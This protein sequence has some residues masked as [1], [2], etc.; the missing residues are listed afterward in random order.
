MK[1]KDF[2][3][4]MPISKKLVLTMKLTF[5]LIVLNVVSCLASVYAQKVSLDLHNVKFSVAISEISKQTHLDFAYS[6]DFV[7]LNR[8]VS[9]SVNNTDL[10]SVLNKL[11]EGTDLLHV[12]LNGKIFL[13]PKSLD[14]AIKATFM[15]QQKITGIITDSSTGEPIPGANIVIE[16]SNAGA[17]SDVN[18]KFSIEVSNPNSA[19]VVSF[20]GYGKQRVEIANRS[21]IDVKL[22]PD[23][24][25]L[26]EVVVIGYGTVQKKNLVSAVDQVKASTIEHKPTAT[27]MQALQGAAPSLIIQQPNSEPGAGLNINIR[28]VSTMND[29]SP[30]VV[31]D[32]LVGGDISLLNPSDV[33]SVSILKD[34]GSAAIYGSR[35]AGGVILVTTKKGAKNSQ[36]RVTVNTQTGIQAPHVLYKPVKGYENAILRNQALVNSGS[37]P[38][39]S[40]ETIRQLKENGDSEWFLNTI[41]QNSLQQ[42]YNVSISGGREKSTYMI[43]GGYMS[44]E[45]NLVGPDYG[46]KR[47]NFRMNM[48]NEYGRLKLTTIMAYARSNIKTHTSST[49]TLIVDAARIP[50]YYY[51]KLKDE[52]GRYL[53]NDVLTEFNPLGILEQGG[54]KNSDNDDITANISA[55]LDVF[56]GLK[57]KGVFGGDLKANHSSLLE[58]KVNYYSSST[59]TIP[60]GSSGPTRR[61]EDD[62][63][64]ALFLNSQVMLDYSQK[65]NVHQVNALVGFSNE[66]YTSQRNG[67]RETYT[68]PD[69]NIP[70]SETVIGTGT[71]TTPQATTE[72]SLNSVFGRAG[73]TYKDKYM[74]EFDFRFDGSSKFAKDNRWGFFPSVLAGWRATDES[75]LNWYKNNIGT[76]KLKTSYGILGSQSVDDYQ[77]QTTYFVFNNAYGFNNSSVAGTGFTFANNDLKWERTATFNAGLDA[78]FFAN[79][80]SLSFDWFNKL[81]S[82]ILITPSVP[83]TYGGAVPKYNAGKMRNRGWEVTLNYNS[84]GRIF[85]H[86]V[87]VN[88]SDTR[89]EVVSFGGNVQINSADEMQQVIKAGIP[90]NSYIGYKRDGYFQNLDDIN[91]GAKPIGSTVSPGDVRYKDKNGDGLIDDNDRYVIGNAFPR[92]LFSVNY[93]LTWENFNLSFFIQGVGKRDQF[94]RG[95]LVEPFHA[96][97]SY[98]M[99]QH[100]LDF[101]TP[102]NPNAKYPRLSAPGSAS[103]ANNYG[104]ASDLHI[105]DASYVRLKNVQLGYTMP[106]KLTQ[107]IGIPKLYIY[108]TAQNLFTLS[109]L[110]FVDPESTEYNSNMSNSGANSARNY[111]TLQYYGFGVDVNF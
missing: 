80:L 91:N 42:N 30:L 85:K 50:T 16:G 18:G 52:N 62:N 14:S 79:K 64:K 76:L 36:T 65:F 17:T 54:A 9:I 110:S 46:I 96:S 73:Y 34:A 43:S 6:K 19:L 104:K 58:K 41:L 103:N 92:Y 4:G 44:Q 105:F 55:E 20:I 88:L 1:K 89:N 87:T 2:R 74:M 81:T 47:Y 75:F 68:D 66:S 60:S 5:L 29:N 3:Q 23:V 59:A 28:G 86:S 7:D 84:T 51:Y 37:A 53:V 72:R 99:Y 102:V 71:Y 24:Q 11:L 57:L 82:D 95:E 106:R 27:L 56:K 8:A 77:Y 31:I 40:A 109:N 83:G 32:G 13:G 67:I 100:Q 70:V 94:L 22:V 45:S 78:A 101:W 26:E 25:K 10:K 97:Y 108:V 15:K 39:Y 48:T 35:S 61:T 33:E 107:K 63:E 111:P 21:S 93:D 90:F 38:L 98:V 12:E 69:L 49:G